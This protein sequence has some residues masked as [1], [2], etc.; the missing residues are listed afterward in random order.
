MPGRDKGKLIND[1]K[2]AKHLSDSDKR[3]IIDTILD[4]MNEDKKK[5]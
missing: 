5:K 3:E 4:K 2:N 1:I